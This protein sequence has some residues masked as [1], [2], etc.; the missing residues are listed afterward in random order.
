[1][2]SFTVSYNCINSAPADSTPNRWSDTVDGRKRVGKGTTGRD[3]TFKEPRESIPGNRF[4]QPMLSETVLVNLLRS[5]VIDSQPG[6]IDYSESIPGLH[7][8]LQ[9]RALA[10]RHD[11]QGFRTGP[12]DWESI[13]GL[14][15]RS[16]DT[17]S[18]QCSSVGQ[19]I[20]NTKTTLKGS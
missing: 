2:Y 12:P 3:R 4:R 7:K 18:V 8:R 11:K 17:G 20:G 5:P 16:T 19:L 15:K 6:E 1:M 9:I 10:G 14:L 13:P